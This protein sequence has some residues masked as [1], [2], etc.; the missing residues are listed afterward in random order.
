MHYLPTGHLPGVQ[1]AMGA[2]QNP[3]AHLYPASQSAGFSQ[4][5]KFYAGLLIFVMV[6]VLGV[7]SSYTWHKP[8]SPQ[9]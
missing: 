9:T 7:T 4:A 3:T 1:A 2:L 5:F 8:S 6:S